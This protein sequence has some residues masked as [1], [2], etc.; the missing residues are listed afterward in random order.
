MTEINQINIAFIGDTKTG[1][2][3]L[4]NVLTNGEEFYIIEDPKTQHA[5]KFIITITDFKGKTKP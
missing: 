2:K 3:T 1:K 5:Y 4:K